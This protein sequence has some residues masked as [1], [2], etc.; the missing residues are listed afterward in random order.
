MKLLHM[1]V[2]VVN[3]EQKSEYCSPE[4]V[5]ALTCSVLKEETHFRGRRWFRIGGTGNTPTSCQ[6]T[7]D[8][9]TCCVCGPLVF[10]ISS[11]M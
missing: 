6:D 11:Q 5:L 4:I 3:H 9:K 1:R 7:G 8:A 10:N 2:V